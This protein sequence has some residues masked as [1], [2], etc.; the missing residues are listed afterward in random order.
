MKETGHGF[1]PMPVLFVFFFRKG[2]CKT[3]FGKY[4]G[5]AIGSVEANRQQAEYVRKAYRPEP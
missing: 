5:F 1:D 3:S 2:N 4:E